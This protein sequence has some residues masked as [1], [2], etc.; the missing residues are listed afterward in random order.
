[1]LLTLDTNIIIYTALDCPIDEKYASEF[2]QQTTKFL[3]QKVY[4]ESKRLEE[5]ISMFQTLLETHR[6]K[7]ETPQETFDR[8]G[9]SIKPK[10]KTKL[11]RYF[12]NIVGY[13]DERFKNG[14]TIQNITDSIIYDLS[15]YTSLDDRIRPSSE[16]IRTSERKVIE[17]QNV[18]KENNL[19]D[20]EDI[21]IIVQMKIY[22][23]D[24]TQE[25]ELVTRDSG[26][27]SEK[28]EWEKNFP[29]ISVNDITDEVEG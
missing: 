28:E 2:N 20:H 6:T 24:I 11:H 12:N 21:D 10:M 13:Y 3:T 7:G 18:I 4:D 25:M 17:Y 22:Q 1:M 8:V 26:F 27:N 14:D 15:N 9:D 23:D 19:V 5:R 16:Q 29:K